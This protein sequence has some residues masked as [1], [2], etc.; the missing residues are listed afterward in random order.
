LAHWNG[1]VPPGPGNSLIAA[2]AESLWD[3]WNCFDYTHPNKFGLDAMGKS[4]GLSLFRVSES[5]RRRVSW[6]PP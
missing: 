5:R 1:I 6:P 3:A 4:I 2:P